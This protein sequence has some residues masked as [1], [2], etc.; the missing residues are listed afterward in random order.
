MVSLKS[1]AEQ[2]CRE[3]VG[4]SHTTQS[5]LSERVI[6]NTA[7]RNISSKTRDTHDSLVID[8]ENSLEVGVD[9]EQLSAQPSI[10]GNGNAVL[11]SHGD[12][13]VSVVSVEAL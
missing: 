6:C 2:S 13:G 5:N 9:S 10:R 4:M 12:H 8:L 1:L 7:V 11:A 3:L